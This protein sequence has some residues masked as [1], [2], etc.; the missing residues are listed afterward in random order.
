MAAEKVRK[1]TKDVA[2]PYSPSNW[3][4][5]FERME[6]MFDDFVRRPFS[7]SML[8]AFPRMYEPMDAA[9]SIDMYEEGDNIVV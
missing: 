3:F 4:A 1:T 5:P 8:P 6:E 9:P 2:M 7:R